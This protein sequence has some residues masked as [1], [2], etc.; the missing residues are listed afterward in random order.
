MQSCCDFSQV[1]MLFPWWCGGCGVLV[2]SVGAV[3]V[4]LSTELLPVSTATF[5]PCLL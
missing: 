3:V 1:N 5:Y 2:P 4:V